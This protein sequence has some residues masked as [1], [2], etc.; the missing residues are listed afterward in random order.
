MVEEGAQVSVCDLALFNEEGKITDRRERKYLKRNE[1]ILVAHLKYHIT[2]TDTMMFEADFLKS[3]GGFDEENL[4]DEFYLMF[5]ALSK[6]PRFTHLAYTGVYNKILTEDKLIK[7]KEQSFGILK[8]KDIRYIKM[9]HNLVLAIAH[10][11]NKAYG[12]LFIKLLIAGLQSPFGMLGI[13]TG[14]DR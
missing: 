5:K 4:G 12:K 14:A 8:R 1:P 2:C 10:K 7:F 9:R 3:I 11:K 13:L 6:N